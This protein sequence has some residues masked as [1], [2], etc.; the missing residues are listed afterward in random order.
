M[1][2]SVLIISAIILSHTV[3][4]AQGEKLLTQKT[5]SQY[6]HEVWT[7]DDGLPQNSINK[8]AQTP[9]GYLWMGTQEGLTRFD[10]VQF[11]VF[12]KHNTPQIKNNYIS[13]LYV[14]HEGTLWIGTYDGG[15]VTYS[16]KTFSETKGLKLL[17]NS[18]IR[19]IFED[20]AMGMWISIRGRGVMRI[21]SISHH[22]FDTSNGLLS[23]E[24]WN[25][26]EDSR[27]RVWIATEN[28]ISI[29][30]NGTFTSFTM[31]DGLIFSIVNSIAQGSNNSMWLATNHGIQKVPDDLK[32][33]KAFATYGANDGLPDNISYDVK[34]G[35]DG[36][37]WIG[38]R[39]GVARFLDG[40]ISSFMAVD[41]LSYDH[42]STVLIDFEGNIWIGTDG[43]G[44]NVLKDGIFTSFTKKEGMLSNTIWTIFE[45]PAHTKW[46]GTD[47]GL[48]KM[49]GGDKRSF[50]YFTVRDGLY[51]NEIYSLTMDHTGAM[52]VGTVNGIN[53]IV[54]G[55][56]ETITSSIKTKGLII[57]QVFEDSRRRIWIATA[58][59]GL[60]MLSNGA[61]KE[62]NTAKGF[63]SNYI[64]CIAEDRNGNIVV[65]TDGDGL[66]I[67]SDEHQKVITKKDGLSSNFIH[68]LYIDTE[69]VMWIGTF[70][71]GLNR[72]ADGK[73]TPI[74]VNNGLH[75]DLIFRILEDDFGRLW[76][77]SNRGIF[78]V[79]KSELTSFAESK[80]T[81]IT[82]T[83]YGKEDG[84]R[85]T[86]CNG[87]VQ[88][89]GWK[90]YDGTLWFPTN[91]GVAM[92]DPKKIV[93][94]KLP[95]RVIIEEMRVGN[96]VWKDSFVV[97]G[98][99]RFEFRFTGISFAAPKKIRF[100]VKLEGYD[101]E[102]DDIDT[103]RAAYYTQLPPGEYTFRVIAGNS[104][105]VW[106]DTGAAY[107][108]VVQAHFYQTKIFYVT[109]LTL[110]VIGAIALYRLRIRQIHSRQRELERT[111]EERTK[112]L[113]DAND[114][115]SQLLS[116]VA[117]DL[118]TPLI[119]INSIAQ[120]I[121]AF[122]NIDRH[123]RGYL[124][125]VEQNS[126]R[127][128]KL[129]S[130]ILNISAIESGKFQF[131]FE[132]INIAEI[133]AIVVDGY[134][135]QA[136]R[137]EQKLLFT[138]Q[139]D[140]LCVAMADSVK[141]QEAMENLIN[142]AIKYSPRHAQIGVHVE[143]REESVVFT[144][145]DQG[146]GISE[147]DQH[148]L[149]KKF[150]VLSAKPTGGEIATGLGLAIVKEIVEAHHG[151]VYVKSTPPMG[152]TFVIE[153]KRVEK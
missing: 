40:K 70:G 24:A 74:T 67:I 95:P 108:F 93:V 130:E 112:N 132:P 68:S 110:I 1:N 62:Y 73:I 129:I 32:N 122:E 47:N 44:L 33:K 102:W 98:K 51:D 72:F 152:T 90:A 29:Y 149:F 96:Q 125:L 3:C 14:D 60:Y 43:G 99:D 55:K 16:N 63:A 36:T 71:G 101:K 17:E 140:E 143:L 80:I 114:A 59:E 48:V 119:T 41:G 46:I 139:S 82:S 105:G 77:T 19:S 12:D 135:V 64:D 75:D 27:G 131:K 97:P 61:A 7:T 4:S 104:D 107:S 78:H 145:K 92:I 26:C 88:P 11:T 79:N 133:A 103:R 31:N 137:K 28:G 111:V 123:F 38:T 69:N 39:A 106:S 146:P 141:L 153:L 15:L 45:D 37:V 9:D 20:R 128:V 56:V 22:I 83:V 118:K 127:V 147:E 58:G 100:K 53:K 85:S 21:D 89:A 57:S 91:G 144:V 87:G 13:A 52:W 126:Q 136:L 35:N 113:V 76:M 109:L 23:N 54:N 5:L 18:H 34:L 116:F 25:F 121:K 2:R 115:K 151:T 6:S 42:V 120:E 66:V 10:G 86:E 148:Q 94:N 84:L 8:L 81:T 124:D 134:Q 117:H 49:S 65:G 30:D 142:N 138:A 150:H 50:K